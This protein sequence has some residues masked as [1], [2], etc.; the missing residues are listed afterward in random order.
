[1]KMIRFE[2]IKYDKLQKIPFENY[3]GDSYEDTVKCHTGSMQNIYKLNTEIFKSVRCVLGLYEEEMFE[4][5]MEKLAL[6]LAAMLFEIE[7]GEIT[8]QLAKL[9]LKD[10][11]DFETGEYD[12][13]FN[14][15][16]L[17]CVKRDINIIKEYLNEH[18]EVLEEN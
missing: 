8:T 14:A 12:N 6:M 13:L 7:K 4:C 11:E 16:D 3:D 1:M 5:G 18:P 9:T 17:V 15:E 10:I 2:D